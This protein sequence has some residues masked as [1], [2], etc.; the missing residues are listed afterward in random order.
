MSASSDGVGLTMGRVRKV[1]RKTG[2]LSSST[3]RSQ[4]A[5]FT[6]K[7]RAAIFCLSAL[8]SRAAILRLICWSGLCTCNM[9]VWASL[10]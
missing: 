6:I 1:F 10:H 7:S 2:F 8:K 4:H 9:P 3:T 5:G